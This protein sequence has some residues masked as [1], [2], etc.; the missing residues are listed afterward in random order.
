M[1]LVLRQHENAAQVGMQTVAERE[2]DDAIAAAEGHGR[3]GP[4][5]RQGMQARTDA[6]RQDDADRLI[7]HGDPISGTPIED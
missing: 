6:A 4:F 1:G 5:G 3:L 7:M 2:V